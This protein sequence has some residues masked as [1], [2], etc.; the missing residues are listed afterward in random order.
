MFMLLCLQVFRPP[1]FFHFT[2]NETVKNDEEEKINNMTD[3]E[4]DEYL[5]IKKLKQIWKNVWL[6]S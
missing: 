3:E 4:N 6:R 2:L 5:K 1:T